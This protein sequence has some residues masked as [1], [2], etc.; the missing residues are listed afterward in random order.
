M[1][2]EHYSFLELKIIQWKFLFH[3]FV[4]ILVF[5]EI[6]HPWSWGI[7]LQLRFWQSK[8]KRLWICNFGRL[9]FEKHSIWNVDEKWKLK[10]PKWST[11]IGHRYICDTLLV[12]KK[13]ACTDYSMSTKHILTFIKCTYTVIIEFKITCTCNKLWE[14]EKTCRL[15]WFLIFIN[16][17]YLL[18]YWYTVENANKYSIER[19]NPKQVP[20]LFRFK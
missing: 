10:E 6:V 4:F 20:K 13:H 1:K 9:Y 17:N 7:L 5:F 3:W 12:W 19:P 11:L 14:N 15:K 8:L 18:S 2:F 16:P